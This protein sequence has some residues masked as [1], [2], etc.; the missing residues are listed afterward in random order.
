MYKDFTPTKGDIEV[1][2]IDVVKLP[3]ENSILRRKIGI[4]QEPQLLDTRNAFENIAFALEVMGTPA[5]EVESKTNTLI[6]L[7]ELNENAF[8]FPSQLSAVSKHE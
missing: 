3:M 2:G 4:T 5:D 7:V 6:E 1:A 8:K